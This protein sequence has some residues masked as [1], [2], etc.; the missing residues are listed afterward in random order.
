M[1]INEFLGTGRS[2]EF[3]REIAH[4]C[5]LD[6]MVNTRKETEES[7]RDAWLWKVETYKPETFYRKGKDNESIIY[8]C[9]VMMFTGIDRLSYCELGVLNVYTHWTSVYRFIRS[10]N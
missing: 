9:S 4:T 2:A 1:R 5:R 7:L 6:N 3:C 10:L 8:M